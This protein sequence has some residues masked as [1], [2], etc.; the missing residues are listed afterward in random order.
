MAKRRRA[1]TLRDKLIGAWTLV[2]YVQQDDP[3]GPANH[4]F[5]TDARGLIMYTPDGYMSAQLMAAGRPN[6]DRPMP[7]GGTPTQQAAAAAGYLA[8]S[9]PYFVDEA[10]GEIRHEPTVSLIPN[11]LGHTLLRPAQLDGNELTLSAVTVTPAGTTVRS[12][13]TWARAAHTADLRT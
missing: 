4:P 8:Y 13:M 2:S 1:L 6:Y 9:G 3:A 5:G 7:D 11:W 10:T 12:T